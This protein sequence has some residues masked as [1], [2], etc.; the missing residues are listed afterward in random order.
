MNHTASSINKQ[1]GFGLIEILLVIIVIGVLGATG[2]YALHTKHQTDKILSQTDKISQSE[3]P[4]AG[5]KKSA[6]ST[7]SSSSSSSPSSQN[8]LVI[9]EWSV[10]LPLSDAISDAYY[11]VPENS[12][13]FPNAYGLGTKSLTALD[14]NCAPD[15]TGVAFIY[16]QTVATHDQNAT[17][18]DQT[19]Y[20]V[21]PTKI[22]NYYYGYANAQSACSQNATT[23]QKQARDSTAFKTAFDAITAE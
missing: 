7:G 22:G 15:K 20:P 16:R 4:S 23:N 6:S 1:S 14:S 9:K 10:K 3:S 17:H 12:A 19:N 13:G 11:S 21:Y 2:W 5:D 8:P 18:S